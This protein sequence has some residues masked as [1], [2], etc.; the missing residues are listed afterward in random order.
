MLKTQTN[1][2]GR[3]SCVENDDPL[4]VKNYVG[5]TTIDKLA[6]DTEMTIIDKNGGSNQYCSNWYKVTYGNNKEGYVCGAYVITEVTVDNND[7]DVKKYR[8]SLKSA[9]FPDSYLDKYLVTTP[10]K[11][12]FN[13]IFPDTFQYMN[14]PT[15]ENIEKV[16]PI[17]HFVSRGENIKEFIKS[18]I[19]RQFFIFIRNSNC[20]Y[21][22]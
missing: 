21:S 13:E 18:K 16:T 7:A 11:I 6:C 20:Y 10:G 17:S 14:E 15:S 19:N 9:G 8:E 5:G 2:K 1:L 22:R 12:I 4:N 3:V